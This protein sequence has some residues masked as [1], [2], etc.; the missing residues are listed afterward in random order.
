MHEVITLKAS[1]AFSTALI[2]SCFSTSL[3]KYVRTVTLGESGSSPKCPNKVSPIASELTSPLIEMSEKALGA[4]SRFNVA[5][6]IILCDSTF[7]AR[8]PTSD[9]KSFL[10]TYNSLTSVMATTVLNA[11]SYIPNNEFSLK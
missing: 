7:G 8:N 4:S 6:L 2:S 5:S 1:A 3:S 9:S 10:V 11:V